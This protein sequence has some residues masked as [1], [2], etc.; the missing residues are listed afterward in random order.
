MFHDK[1]SYYP[2]HVD[3]RGR[4]CLVIGGGKVAERKVRSLITCEA[5]ITLVSPEVTTGLK[6]LIE[7]KKLLYLQK[8]YQESDLDQAFLVI[9]ATDQSE[10]NRQIYRDALRRNLL[11]NVVDSPECCNFIIPAFVKRGDLLLSVSTGGKSPALAG[12]IRKKWEGEFGEEYQLFLEVLGELREKIQGHI[13]DPLLRK[14]L[15]HQILDSDLLDLLR[16]GDFE[17]ARERKLALLK[18]IGRY[19][20]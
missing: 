8:K 5:E 14:K 17:S 2:I 3:L 10:V 15:I 11:V 6:D 12:K 20:G 18:E 13:Q 16:Q 7:K 4:K 9:A 1:M 19:D